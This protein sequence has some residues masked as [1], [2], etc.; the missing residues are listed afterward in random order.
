MKKKSL[1]TLG[2]IMEQ[3]NIQT[4]SMSRALHV[5]ASLISKWKTGDRNI[6]AKSIYFD[7][8]IDYLLEQSTRTI[9][10]NLK[11]ALMDLYP[12]ESIEDETQL[13]LLLRQALSNAQ[14]KFKS[15][16]KQLLSDNA[17]TISAL[18]F[19]ENSGRR[20]AVFKILDFAATMTTPGEL[21]FVDNEE[22]HWLLEDPSYAKEFVCRM[23]ELI[24]KG[25]HATFVLRYASYKSRFIPLFDECSPL[26]FHRN[27]HWYYD[28]YYDETAIHFSF[29]ILNRAISLL[30]FSSD[31]LHSSTMIFTD[32]SL[33][34]QH[35]L[36]ARQ[37][38]AHCNPIFTNFE[39]AEIQKVI[40]D[41][42][43]FRKKGTLYSY[44]PSPAFIAVKE[45]LLLEI[46]HTNE[47]DDTTIKKCQDI[48]QNLKELVSSYF[49]LSHKRKKD[50]FIYIFHLEELLKRAETPAFYSR[51]LTLCCDTPIQIQAAQYAKELRYLAYSLMLHDN[52]DIVLVSDRD[53]ISLPSINCWCKQNIWMVQMNREGLRL[54]A[55]Y[56]VVSAASTKWEHCIRNV[57]SERKEKS[58]VY[59]FLLEL[60]KDIEE[61]NKAGA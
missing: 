6:S 58:S 54:S 27:I 8:I 21:L 26:I 11:N 42:S 7:D 2:Y 57:P 41:V 37:V 61:K 46:L 12:H 4:V 36:M 9:H 51:S 25:F 10:Q 50:G 35:E 39:I 18:T 3:L 15:P 5:D 60:A 34:I 17:N 32:P 52:M 14:P 45:S 19:D 48:N 1:S 30:G 56:S 59:E 20:E 49:S 23:E 28:A 16:E 43:H 24:H 44:L 13:S 40:Y 38:L 47:V 55:E 31:N 29:F 33:V 53:F 22:F